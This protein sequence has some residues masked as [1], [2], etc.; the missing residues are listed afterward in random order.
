MTPYSLKRPL[1]A[2]IIKKGLY[3][4][5]HHLPHLLHQHT[6][7]QIT[8]VTLHA[9]LKAR[10]HVLINAIFSVEKIIMVIF[11]SNIFNELP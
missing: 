7:G 4:L 2:F 11:S 5:L 1:A 3:H 6:K 8:A 9:E 10:N